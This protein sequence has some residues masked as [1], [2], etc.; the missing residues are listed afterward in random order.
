MGQMWVKPLADGT[1]AVAV[2]NFDPQKS[3]V[4]EAAAR[5]IGEALPGAGC[6]VAFEEWHLA[7]GVGDGGGSPSLLPPGVEYPHGKFTVKVP[8]VDVRLFHFR[9]CNDGLC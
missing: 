3:L 8:P 2:V 4:L 9:A 1:V 5:T 7:A 6:G